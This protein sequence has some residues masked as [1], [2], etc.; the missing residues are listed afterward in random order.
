MF[1]RQSDTYNTA[2]LSN[3]GVTRCHCNGTNTQETE[4]ALKLLLVAGG[5]DNISNSLVVDRGLLGVDVLV[6][7]IGRHVA[8]P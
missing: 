3:P 4:V 5:I 2:T 8:N 7:Y 6:R 1:N